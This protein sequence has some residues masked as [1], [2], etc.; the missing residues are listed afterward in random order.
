LN[1]SFDEIQKL[2]SITRLE[3]VEMDLNP[4]D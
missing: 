1:Q 2:A 4:I 3:Y